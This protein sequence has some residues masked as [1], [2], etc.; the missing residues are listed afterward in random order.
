MCIL[1]QDIQ[2][3]STYSDGKN[4]LS[5]MVEEAISCGLKSIVFTDHACGW[6][7]KEGGSVSFF[8]TVCEYESYLSELKK[9]K[10]EYS[11]QIRILSG[12]EIE[13][14]IK[15]GMK[16]SPAIQEYSRLNNLHK[17]GVDLILGSIHSESFEEDCIKY[18]ISSQQKKR[19]ALLTNMTALLSTKIIDVFAHP[20]QAL[21]GHF[22]NNLTEDEVAMLLAVFK[23]EVLSGH[24]IYLEINGKK[25][26]QY[27]QWTY[28]KYESGELKHNEAYFLSA[29][30]KSGGKFVLGSDAHSK[31][32]L[33]NTDFSILDILHCKI[34]DVKI[35]P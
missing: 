22:S 11:N 15:G 27:E 29:Y 3:H 8:S 4:S 19:E 21:H 18:G 9:M 34:D 1:I 16:L 30:R 32:G 31:V 5:E 25:Y 13:V 14:G 26:P 17:F 2:T 23:S 33:T 35:F 28:N 12:L 24:N 20:L 10:N 6:S 7:M